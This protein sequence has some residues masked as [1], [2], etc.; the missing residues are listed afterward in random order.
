MSCRQPRR[1]ASGQAPAPSARRA[2]VAAS[3]VDLRDRSRAPRLD[4]EAPGAR[5]GRTSGRVASMQMKKRSRLASANV[6]HVEDR[7]V[8]LGQA[9][10]GQHAE[11]RRA[12]AANRIVVSKVGGMKAGQLWRGRPPMFIG[13][14]MT[15]APVLRA[16]SRRCSRRSRRRARAGAASEWWMAERLRQLL[17]RIGRVGVDLAVA[18]LVHALAPPPPRS[19]GSSNSAIR[20]VERAAPAVAARHAVLLTHLGP[21]QD[22]AHLE[23]RDRG[24]EAHEQEEQG[25]EQADGAD[26]GRPVPERRAGTCPRTRAGSRGAGWSR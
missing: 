4:Q 22:R 23:D 16:R 6:R 26:E 3:V 13:Y 5:R 15:D 10:Q 20:P 8:G 14:S 24:Q 9:V 11:H 17:D 12:S 1:A 25:E 21:G 2:R 7:V 19:V 18:R